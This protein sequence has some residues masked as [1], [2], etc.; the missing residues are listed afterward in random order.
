MT[1]RN[2]KEVR[3]SDYLYVL[4]K[5]RKFL[6]I[7][8]LIVIVL[9]TIISFLIP[10]TYKATATIMIPP[11]SDMGFGGLTSLLSGSN[12]A[13]SLGAKLLGVEGGTSEDMLL[14]LLNS[15]SVI[16]KV[17]KKFNLYDYYGVEDENYD[18]LIKRFSGDLLFDPNEYGF[19]EVS[20][21]NKDPETSAEMANYFVEIVDSLNIQLNIEQAK[22]Q[23]K[24]V[25][26]RFLQNQEDLRKAEEA[27]AEFQKKH[28]VFAI[29]EQVQ[30]A[31]SAAGE[32]EAQLVAQQILAE[33]IRSDI[34]TNSLIYKSIQAKINALKSQLKKM[35]SKAGGKN[36]NSLMIPFSKVPDL[37]VE[38]LRRYRDVEIQNKIMEFLYPMY[39]QAKIDEQKS[40][41]TLLVIDKAEVPQL[42]Y[43]PKKAFIILGAFFFFSFIFILFVFRGEEAINRKEFNNPLEEKEKRFFRR[44]G[45]YYKLNI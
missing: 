16:T 21:I 24:F 37:Q 15:R 26:K 4:Y 11:N 23:R 30:V 43:A 39:E 38:Y 27:F 22:R 7:N 1:E 33:T 18:K 32:L 45:N 41:P 3:F 9:S 36:D 6:I 8:L 20:V 25:E 19:I 12:S 31:V 42:K 35:N 10:K 5:W 40:M 34:S 29:P 13:M 2:Q 14:G 28:G 44:V 17:V